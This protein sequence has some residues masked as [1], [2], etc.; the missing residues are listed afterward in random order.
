MLTFLRISLATVSSAG[1]VGWVALTAL[2]AMALS[3]SAIRALVTV[4]RMRRQ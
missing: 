3:W 2:S 4:I 1:P